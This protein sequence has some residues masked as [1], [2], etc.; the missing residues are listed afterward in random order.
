MAVEGEEEKQSFMS[1]S[2][3]GL[4]ILEAMLRLCA[5]TAKINCLYDLT[6]IA[7]MKSSLSSQ[8]A[9]KLRIWSF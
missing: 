8:P 1:S 3:L 4:K 7:E 5:A 9:A 6:V 2:V